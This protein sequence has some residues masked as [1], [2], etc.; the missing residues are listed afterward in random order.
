MKEVVINFFTLL[1]FVGFVLIAILAIQEFIDKAKYKIRQAKWEY[2]YKHR[3]DKPPTAKC[4]CIDCDF[5]YK[6]NGSYICSRFS[7]IN[8]AE[9]WFC[10]LATPKEKDWE[11]KQ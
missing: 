9:N 4:Y 3:F 2:K 10:W 11:G 6:E 8:V 1:G 7:G 5:Q